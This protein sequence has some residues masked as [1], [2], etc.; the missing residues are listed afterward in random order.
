MKCLTI[1]RS[2]GEIETATK[3]RYRQVSMLLSISYLTILTEEA[4]LLHVSRAKFLILL[5]LRRLGLVGLARPT[6]GPEY[7]F[8]EDELRRSERIVWHLDPDLK[9]RLDRVCLLLGHI[10]PHA[11]VVFELNQWIG[12]PLGFLDTSPVEA[13]GAVEL[14]PA[15]DAGGESTPA[16]PTGKPKRG[17]RNEKPGTTN[18]EAA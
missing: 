18:E 4:H 7:T 16:P 8:S 1:A 17:T 2:E 3:P 11:W 9:E 14:A 12:R 15:R 13:K 5:L 10:T 6:S